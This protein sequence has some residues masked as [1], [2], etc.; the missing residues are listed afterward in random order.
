MLRL[1]VRA[2]IRSLVHPQLVLFRFLQ[3]TS[4]QF[5]F[6]EH[7]YTLHR[8]RQAS[9]LQIFPSFDM[10]HAT[11]DV[12]ATATILRSSCLVSLFLVV[13]AAVLVGRRVVYS[14]VYACFFFPAA[15]QLS[16]RG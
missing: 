7:K 2:P 9:S 13:V 11:V 5:T 3:P 4:V 10:K 12:T 1:R 16:L 6:D 8:V 15:Q 14:S